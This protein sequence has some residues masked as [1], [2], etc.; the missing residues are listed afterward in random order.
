[1]ASCVLCIFDC[2]LPHHF[3]CCC[4]FVLRAG[5]A[6][7]SSKLLSGDAKL[8]LP[9]LL[10]VPPLSILLDQQLAETSQTT[11]DGVNKKTS[12]LDQTLFGA[13]CSVDKDG[14]L[15]L[16]PL[17]IRIRLD[18]PTAG[19]FAILRKLANNS[20]DFQTIYY[21][22]SMTIRAHTKAPF[23][24]HSAVPQRTSCTLSAFKKPPATTTPATMKP[25]APLTMNGG[26]T[27]I[28]EEE[29]PH[30]KRQKVGD[31]AAM[32]GGGK[33]HAND[34]GGGCGTSSPATIEDIMEEAGRFARVLVATVDPGA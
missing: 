34:G 5:D 29:H 25:A 4:H 20:T 18:S 1:M 23:L 6:V 21:C 19:T 3:R 14:G 30:A 8:P 31:G 22:I 13:T 28:V 12:Y 9:A 26:G 2:T 16:Y 33:D 11:S 27:S 7:E 32:N 17:D 10:P 15:T 24:A